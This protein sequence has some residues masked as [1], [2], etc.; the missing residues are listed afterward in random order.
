M[1]IT[2][3]GG[4]LGGEIKHVDAEPALGTELVFDGYRYRYDGNG[5]AT[6]SG[7]A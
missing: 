2:L 7:M 1:D 3:S 4:D 5:T 6:F